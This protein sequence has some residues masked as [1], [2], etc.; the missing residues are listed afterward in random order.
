MDWEIKVKYGNSAFK[1]QAEKVYESAQI[2]RIKVHGNKGH[3]LLEN[4]YPFLQFSKS[5]KAINWKVKESFFDTYGNEQNAQLIGDI[6]H[7]LE[8]IIKG[9]NKL[10][11]VEHIKNS[12]SW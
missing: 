12:K 4:N 8:N 6:I 5:N 1:L 10:S 7:L 9:K 11:Y 2:M 3:L